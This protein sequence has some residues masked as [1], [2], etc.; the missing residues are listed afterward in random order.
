MAHGFLAGSRWTVNFIP[1]EYFHD[2]RL[3]S[4]STWLSSQPAIF[5]SIH[6]FWCFKNAVWVPDMNQVLRIYSSA[7]MWFHDF[8]MC[9]FY[10]QGHYKQFKDLIDG[11]SL[12]CSHLD[13][14][15]PQP[16]AAWSRTSVP[17]QRL[18]LDSGRRSVESE[19]LEDSALWRCRKEFPQRQKVV[20]QSVC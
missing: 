8:F 12:F 11:S 3:I 9:L 14:R 6:S 5:D 10:F 18:R 13:L 7:W 20:K 17:S 15:W 2:D 19:P 16:E 4:W 1:T